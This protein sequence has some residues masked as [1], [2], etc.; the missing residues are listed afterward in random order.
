LPWVKTAIV[1]RDF[2][3]GL[4]VSLQ[5][6]EPAAYW[7][8]SQDPP[9]HKNAGDPLVSDAPHVI[10]PTIQWLNTQGHVFETPNEEDKKEDKK[11]GKKTLPTLMG[12]PDSAQQVW[13]FYEQ[14]DPLLQKIA[15][16][17]HTLEL[18]E[19]GS[20]RFQ[21]SRPGSSESQGT[22]T[23]KVWVELGVGSPDELLPKVNRFV[24]TWAIA[25]AVETQ[26]TGTLTL[27]RNK[28]PLLRTGGVLN[29][30]T[31]IDLRHHDG[32]AFR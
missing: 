31:A 27:T 22:H 21:I 17:I 32:Y 7:Q 15:S 24:T 2:P 20:W 29:T 5:E 13:A 14:L 3:H 25:T 8:A 9:A 18:T 10:K 23:S 30:L 19:H 1:K 11:E 16:H 28:Q 6:H 4:V 26:A 12:P